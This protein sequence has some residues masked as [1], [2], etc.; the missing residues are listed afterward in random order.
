MFISQYQDTSRSLVNHQGETDHGLHLWPH[1]LA[2]QGNS[3]GRCPGIFREHGLMMLESPPNHTTT[4]P[5]FLSHT[6]GIH[7]ALFVPAFQKI[8]LAPFIPHGQETIRKGRA[9][10]QKNKKVLEKG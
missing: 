7:K 5:E 8:P 9:L 10:C 6:L 4:D 3:L 1:I 2:E